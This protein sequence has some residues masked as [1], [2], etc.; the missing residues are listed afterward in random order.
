MLL[1]A[2]F[3]FECFDLLGECLHLAVALILGSAK[4][5]AM[6]K[7]KRLLPVLEGPSHTLLLLLEKSF[8]GTAIFQLK[9]KV[10]DLLLQECVLLGEG[11]AVL[12]KLLRLNQGLRVL[13]VVHVVLGIVLHVMYE[14]G[15]V[16]QVGLRPTCRFGEVCGPILS[17]T[18]EVH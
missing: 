16:R 1:H 17:F 10:L 14:S 13:K 3:R 2:Q 15:P 6:L 5:L 11:V 4:C 18:V 8:L 9:A 7:G 12:T